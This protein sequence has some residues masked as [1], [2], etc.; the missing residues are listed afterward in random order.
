MHL[1]ESQGQGQGRG[2]GQGQGQG[3][4]YGYGKQVNTAYLASRNLQNQDI[5]TNSLPLTQPVTSAYAHTPMT[6]SNRLQTLP[7]MN[8]HPY[9]QSPTAVKVYGHATGQ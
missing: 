1:Q 9:Q 7:H 4:V 6:T 3:Q 2:Q 5:S 8:S